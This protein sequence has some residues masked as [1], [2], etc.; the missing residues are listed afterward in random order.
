MLP[1][2]GAS[3][4]T[5]I[6]IVSWRIGIRLNFLALVCGGLGEKTGV[7]VLGTKNGVLPVVVFGAPATVPDHAKTL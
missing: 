1:R 6:R 5:Y 3:F 7:A 2:E 4:S